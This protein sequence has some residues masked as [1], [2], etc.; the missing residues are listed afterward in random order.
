MCSALVQNQPGLT[1]SFCVD[2]KW[3]GLDQ[4]SGGVDHSCHSEPQQRI[5]GILASWVTIIER[6]IHF[7][8]TS[9]RC[10][11]QLVS[12]WYSSE[13]PFYLFNVPVCRTTRIFASILSCLFLA[14]WVC[15]VAMCRTTWRIHSIFRGTNL[16]SYVC[17][18]CAVE[19]GSILISWVNI[20]LQKF[21]KCHTITWVNLARTGP[22]SLPCWPSLQSYHICCDGDGVC[23]GA[24]RW[25]HP[26]PW[27]TLRLC[28]FI[29]VISLPSLVWLLLY[30][31]FFLSLKFSIY[32]YCLLMYIRVDDDRH[33]NILFIYCSLHFYS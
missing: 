5:Q 32:F 20:F 1:K 26:Q 25:P 12:I 13:L 30:P 3:V 7:V 23:L 9:I 22:A 14:T 11:V 28:S 19:L 15:H 6:D 4:G 16:F 17:F 29:P 31:G 27:L 24:E 21:P 18:Q 2:Q 33:H 10:A 8:Y